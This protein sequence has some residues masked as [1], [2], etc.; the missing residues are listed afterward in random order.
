MMALKYTTIITIRTMTTGNNPFDYDD[1]TTDRLNCHVVIVMMMMKI[2]NVCSVHDDND[3]DGFINNDV[4]IIYSQ[5]S[6]MIKTE[7]IKC[8]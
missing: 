8:G 3:D 1:D 2:I 4:L 6:I 5:S 7:Q